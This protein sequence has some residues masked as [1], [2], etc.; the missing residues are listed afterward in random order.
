[1]AT[2]YDP[3]KFY[4]SFGKA[5]GSDGGSFVNLG[6]DSGS[7][8]QANAAPTFGTGG[9]LTSTGGGYIVPNTTASLGRGKV[10]LNKSV[11]DQYDFFGDQSQSIIQLSPENLKYVTDQNQVKYDPQIGYYVPQSG[12]TMPTSSP[13]NFWGDALK[14]VL[15]GVGAATG[16]FS[17]V[18]GLSGLMGGAAASGFNP[19]G[20]DAM[21]S[22][23]AVPGLGE[24]VQGLSSLPSPITGAI[25]GGVNSALT[26][27]DPLKGAIAGGV[28]STINSGIN[29][30]SNAL[31]LPSGG[32]FDWAKGALGNYATGSV[33][34][35][36]WGNNSSKQPTQNSNQTG[37]N[38]G[39]NTQSNLWGS[40]GG[41]MADNSVSDWAKS[42][43]PFLGAYTANSQRNDTGDT[44]NKAYDLITTPSADQA[45]YRGQ[46]A[47]L[48][49]NPGSMESSPVYQAML[50]QGTNAVNRTAAAKGMLGSGNRLGDLM[51]MGQSTA[52]QYYFPQQQALASLSGV[53]GD[54]AQRTLGAG[55]LIQGQTAQNEM[56]TGMLKEL[57][58]GF[59]VQTPQD[60]LLAAMTGRS[61]GDA[62]G[63][64]PLL[65]AIQ[66]AFG[67]G[68]TGGDWNFDPNGANTAYDGTWQSGLFDTSSPD[69]QTWDDY[70]TNW[71]QQDQ[72]LLDQWNPDWFSN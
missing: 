47:T 72:Q 62:T 19:I 34:G 49:D 25:K 70:G 68:S 9:N 50:D 31:G 65:A 37:M 29:A 42:L 16:M 35:D 60:Q 10:A 4:G 24:A 32:V 23:N 51:K 15:T 13:D 33:L 6:G 12:Y 7:T 26:G 28:G 40:T 30:G 61:G 52:S 48:M 22:S 27:G 45:K 18:A 54:S 46:L 67:G 41:N 69:Y 66:K 17:G 20:A 21:W 71:T 5:I 11:M 38:S 3:S 59:G 43:A 14:G 55:S 58:K 8:W 36:L 63:S 44:F 39:D 64:N 1:M 57:M 53:Q 2:N 56:Q